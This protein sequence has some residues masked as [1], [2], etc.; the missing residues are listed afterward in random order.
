[1]GA[2]VQRDGPVGAAAVGVSRS[3]TLPAN[4]QPL[5]AQLVQILG[6]QTLKPEALTI[7][8]D[9]DGVAQAVKPVISFQRERA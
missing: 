1:M 7:H 2:A 3:M 8:F 6:L 9:R 4:A 5:I